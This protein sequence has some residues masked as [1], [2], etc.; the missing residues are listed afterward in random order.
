MIGFNFSF[1]LETDILPDSF[2]K[3]YQ[4]SSSEKTSKPAETH[5]EII[6]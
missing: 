6:F 5:F 2:S 1:L 4:L 3:E